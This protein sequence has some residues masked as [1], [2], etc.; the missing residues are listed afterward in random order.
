MLLGFVRDRT[1]LF[2]TILFPLMFLV[3][4]GGLLKNQGVSRSKVIEVGPVAVIDQVPADAKRELGKLL[5]VT[6]MTDRAKALDAVRKGDYEAAVEQQGDRVMVHYSAADQV[7]AGTVRS[8]F[9][10]LVQQTNLAAAGTPPRLSL[11]AQQVEDKSLKTIQFVTPG[12][13]GWAIAT[14][15]TFGAAMTLV[16]WRE[17]KILRRLRLSPVR[18][19]SV[20]SARVGVSV[21]VALLQTAIFLGVASLPSFG[22]KLS[23]YWWMSLPVILVGT[24]AF[25]SIGLVAGAW[26]KTQESAN[27]IA[28]LVVLP[29][30][31]LSG[32]FFPLDSAP[33]WLQAVAEIFPLRH[34]NQAMLDVMVRGK[35]PASV[36][37]EMGILAGFAI[38]LTLLATRL[39]RWDD[40]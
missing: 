5:D 25:L 31:F 8:V 32:S 11:D 22:L 26:A 37:P 13:L 6:K 7:R 18:I 21:G 12:L 33:K 15:A 29:M 40:V 3:L 10:Q 38:V 39:F 27:V 20:V 36:L 2:F 4:F 35:G 28:Q 34:L 17:K 1:A 19:S 16:T 9:D 14:G 24:F 23:N 30:A